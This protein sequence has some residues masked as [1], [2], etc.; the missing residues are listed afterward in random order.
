MGKRLDI[1]EALTN[2]AVGLLFSWAV[3]YIA[4]PLWGLEPSAGDA[5]GITAMYFFVS[6]AR[7]YVL[8]RVFRRLGNG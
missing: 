2:A 3:T 5:V 4:L 7:S 8:R 1:T 6:M